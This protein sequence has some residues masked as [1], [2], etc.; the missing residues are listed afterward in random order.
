MHILTYWQLFFLGKRENL[1]Q[2]IQMQL[3]KKLKGFSAFLSAFRK[4][5]FHFKNFGKKDEPHSLYIF[6]IIE[7]EIRPYVKV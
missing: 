3:S 7:S 6:D 5:T 2:P 1:K 4:S